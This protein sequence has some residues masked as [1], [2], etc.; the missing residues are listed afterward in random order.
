MQREIKFRV[1]DGT[2]WSHFTLGQSWTGW[3]QS[4]YDEHCLN[5]RKFCQ[6]TGI[7][8][9]NGVEIFEGDVIQFKYYNVYK[10][11]WS[12]KHEIPKIEAEV[13]QQRN[14]VQ[15]QIAT[16]VFSDGCF[17]LRDGYPLTLMDV[18]RGSRF[19]K[20]QTSQCDTEEKQWDFEVMGN[21]YETPE[22]V[23]R[24]VGV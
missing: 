7:T 22:H 23:S 3:M 15:L 17:I 2:Q 16:V 24:A 13:E 12:N 20:G 14:H 5:G 8:D 18:K 21:V 19:K 4:V 9:K 1:W 10:R 11:W 6:S